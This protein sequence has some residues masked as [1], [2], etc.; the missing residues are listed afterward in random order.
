MT[1]LKNTLLFFLFAFTIISLSSCWRDIFNLKCGESILLGTLKLSDSTKAAY[2]NW[3]GKEVL[4]FKDSLGNEQEY[5]SEKGKTINTKFTLGE[6]V[7]C[8]SGFLDRQIEYFNAEYQVINFANRFDV[9]YSLQLLLSTSF[10]GQKD[11]ALIYDRFSLN[12]S[13]GINGSSIYLYSNRE[14]PLPDSIK[15][16]FNV[17]HRFVADTTIS[18]KNFKDVYYATNDLDKSAIY[19]QKN[20]MIIGFKD[21]GKTWLLDKIK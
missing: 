3:T 11:S 1:A 10:D 2:L 16:R 14:K 17:Y 7:L 18:G 9:K 4:F 5:F 15:K 19:F 21:A 6:N 12:F 8:D 13:N 20:K